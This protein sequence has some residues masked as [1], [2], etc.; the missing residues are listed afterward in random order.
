MTTMETINQPLSP[1][2]QATR[3][4]AAA[5][6]KMTEL[7]QQEARIRQNKGQA[8]RDLVECQRRHQQAVTSARVQAARDNVDDIYKDPDVVARAKDV[9]AANEKLVSWEQQET[10]IR[11]ER[12]QN[13]MDVMHWQRRHAEATKTMR[14]AD[15]ART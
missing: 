10:K 9:R 12:S 7:Q 6:I 3:G 11:Q 4:L 8:E 1:I 14:A 5:N 15:L 13:E 2:A